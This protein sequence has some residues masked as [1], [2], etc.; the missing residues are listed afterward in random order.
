MR[1]AG[2]EVN[3][4]FCSVSLNKGHHFPTLV[5]ESEQTLSCARREEQELVTL[6]A[7]FSA[8]GVH[9]G[10]CSRLEQARALENVTCKI[11]LSHSSF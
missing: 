9:L 1:R 10:I 8:A 3:P 6:T 2:D 4:E 11:G 7:L 5:T